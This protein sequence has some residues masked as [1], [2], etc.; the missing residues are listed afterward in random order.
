MCFEYQSPE[1]L[2][3]M[4][5]HF[6]MEE[7]KYLAEFKLHLF[8]KYAAPV[9][10]PGRKLEVLQ[11]GF[12]HPT[13][14]KVVFNARAE[15]AAKNPLFRGA[16]KNARCLLPTTGFFEHDAQ[17]RKYLIT[18]PEPIFA[19]AGLYRRG[20]C[21][22][23][24]CAPNAVMERIHNRM[25]VILQKR[26]YDRWLIDGDASLL[27]PYRGELKTTVVAEPKQPAFRQ[28]DLF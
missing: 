1:D 22:M 24:T 28:G 11:W 8:P 12:Q 16:V 3:A 14:N 2:E 26:D 20:E 25:P 17:R 13:L 15:T 5:L 4:R 7:A 10:L 23:L 27:G 19:F 21:T 18:L 9:I 6:E